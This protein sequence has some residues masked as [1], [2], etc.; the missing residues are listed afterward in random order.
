MGSIPIHIY[1]HTNTIDLKEFTASELRALHIYV[2]GF[3]LPCGKAKCNVFLVDCTYYEIV[4]II[5]AILKLSGSVDGP[6]I[7]SMHLAPPN[8]PGIGLGAIAIAD[9]P[10][11]IY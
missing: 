7:G 11:Y 4:M 6:G 3:L 9:R 10:D 8:R 1:L 5:S 2:R